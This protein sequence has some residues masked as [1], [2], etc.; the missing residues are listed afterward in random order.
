MGKQYKKIF[1]VLFAILV[2]ASIIFLAWRGSAPTTVKVENNDEWRD[3]LKVVP[4]ERALKTTNLTKGN[5]ADSFTEAT[6]TTDLV[7]R[8]LLL[9]YT[10][11]QRGSATSTISDTQAQYIARRLAEDVKLPER[12]EYALSDLNI[13]SDNT[14]SAGILYVNALNVLLKNHMETEK[15]ETELTILLSAMDTKSTATL[16]KLRV[17]AEAYQV[18]IKNLLAMKT[19]SVFAPLHLRFVQSYESLR[20]GTVGL[21]SMLA[22]PVV[23]ISALAEYRNGVD[24]LSIAEQG[25][26]NLK[27]VNNL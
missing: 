27:I 1:S 22:D 23:G 15:N 17:K 8:R 10:A 4:Q 16:N 21:E 19:P 14:R 18:L 5:L 20:S 9:E 12:K 3:V 13:S 7:A 11:S 2:G 6:T 25:L 24:E 26:D